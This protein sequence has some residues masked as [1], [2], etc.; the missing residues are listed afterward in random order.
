MSTYTLAEKRIPR[1]LTLSELAHLYEKGRHDFS[2]MTITI[3]PEDEPALKF[4]YESKYP[5]TAEDMKIKREKCCFEFSPEKPVNFERCYLN[6]LKVEGLP[7]FFR[8]GNLFEAELHKSILRNMDIRKANFQGAELNDADLRGSNL[9]RSNLFSC[10]LKNA[11]LIGTDL[12][13]AN[14]AN[15]YLKNSDL[16]GSDAR[17][18][19]RSETNFKGSDLT[20]SLLNDISTNL[21]TNFTNAKLDYADF[22]GTP[23]PET[24]QP[25]QITHAKNIP[26]TARLAEVL[27]RDL[28]DLL[29]IY[30]IL[31]KL[32]IR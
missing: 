23:I 11:K 7:H 32:L 10:W 27:S 16:T 28:S 9:R 20:E 19:E 15:A 14:I 25:R 3:S 12:R 24:I 6:G 29:G 21:Y 13:S 17:G 1:V 30:H 31:G 22:R 5:I 18:T 26:R 8:G 4:L 2:N